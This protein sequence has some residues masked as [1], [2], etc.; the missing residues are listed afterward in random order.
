LQQPL[1]Y[2]ASW[3][4][5]SNPH[6]AG[7]SGSI[8]RY[9][10]ARPAPVPLPRAMR[11]TS[12]TRPAHHSFLNTD[13]NLV[14]HHSGITLVMCVRCTGSAWLARA[15]LCSAVPRSTS[16]TI[17]I[18]HKRTL[19]NKH[20]TC[21]ALKTTRLRLASCP[22]CVT[23]HAR[24]V[25]WSCAICELLPHMRQLRHRQGSASSLQRKRR[26]SQAPR[27]YL[28]DPIPTI[29]ATHVR[30]PSLQPAYHNTTRLC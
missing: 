5:S 27:T 7:N 25:R 12:V 2:I 14:R 28:C 22:C 21:Q 16:P 15:V 24:A 17:R 13:E 8:R 18:T 26:L 6:N 19:T 29:A 10:K 9:V 1:L 3:A 4:N 20:R 23:C 30:L 11:V